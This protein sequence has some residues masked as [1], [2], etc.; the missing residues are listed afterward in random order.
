MALNRH[1]LITAPASSANLG[2]GFDCFA[3]ALDLEL[4]LEVRETGSFAVVTDLDVEQGRDNLVV[5]AF[6][7][8]A[9]PSSFEFRISSTIP[10]CGGLGSSAAAVVAGVMAADHIFELDADLLA[11]ATSIEG[12]PDNVGAALRG[13]VVVC[14]DGSA[15]RLPLPGYLEAVIVAP[16]EPVRTS[17]AR[18]ALPA[19]VPMTDAVANVAHAGLLVAGLVS[20]DR[21]LIARGLRDDLHQARRAH[22]FPRSFELLGRAEEFGAIGATISGA[23]PTVLFWTDAQDTGLVVERLRA[24]TSGWAEVIRVPFAETGA[25]VAEL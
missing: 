24:A 16:G 4:R 14:A 12:H 3:A 13:G 19:E 18:A 7:E 22:L 5:R 15:D 21:E 10:L 23:G 8:L 25:D 6:S 1:R 17:E 11:V 9:D 2:P 20:G